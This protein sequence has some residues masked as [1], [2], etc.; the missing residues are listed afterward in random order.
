MATYLKERRYIAWGDTSGPETLT[1]GGNEIPGR[2][3][4]VGCPNQTPASN[5]RSNRIGKEG[6]GGEEEWAE[7]P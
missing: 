4:C 7:R 2:N 3:H 5:I 1:R 6:L